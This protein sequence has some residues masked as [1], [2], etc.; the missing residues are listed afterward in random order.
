M[1]ESVLLLFTPIAWSKAVTLRIWAT[2]LIAR[3][4]HLPLDRGQRLCPQGYGNADSCRIQLLSHVANKQD[5]AADGPCGFVK[6]G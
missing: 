5:D 4:V 3:E 2:S 6:K 1:T